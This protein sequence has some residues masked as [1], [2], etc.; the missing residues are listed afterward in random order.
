MKYR[1][2]DPALTQKRMDDFDF[3]MTVLIKGGSN[4]PGNELYGDFS[5]KA[6]QEKGS[7]NNGGI[8]DPAIDALID[9]VVQS[10]SR[11]DLVAA[12]R[13][14]DRV[15]LHGYYCVPNYFNEKHF[16]AYRTTLAYPS[17]L[18]RQYAASSWV[19]T[20]WWQK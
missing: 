8:A 10:S 6:A 17:V 13:A 4:S 18:P 7:E 19:M 16:I 3:D 14:L 5:S 9:R 20:M 2:L 12:S 15:L 1:T 11:A